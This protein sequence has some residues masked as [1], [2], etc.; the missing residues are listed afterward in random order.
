[1]QTTRKA[2][3]G[4]G[5]CKHASSRYTRSGFSTYRRRR[6]YGCRR[7]SATIRNTWHI[8][9]FAMLIFLLTMMMIV[10]PAIGSETVDRQANSLSYHAEDTIPTS[11]QLLVVADVIQPMMSRVQTIQMQTL[12][13]NAASSMEPVEDSIDD[14]PVVEIDPAILLA[15]SLGNPTIEIDGSVLTRY[16]LPDKYYPGIDFSSFQPYMGYKCITN[17]SSPAYKVTRSEMAYNDEY[18]MRRY[19]T[20]PDQFTI[21]GQDD[22][23]IA[24]GTFYKEKGTAGS[25]YLIVTSTGMYTAIAGDEKSD[26]HTDA[27]HMFSTHQDGSCAGIIEWIVDQENLESTMK[28][29][30]TITAGPIEP[31]KGEILHIYGIN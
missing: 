5:G 1:M 2:S 28:R 17:K 15:E 9:A 10:I 16:D 20:T 22:Y 8:I 11:D 6:G 7:R 26:A 29:A 13:M 27:R 4:Y 31:L 21:D 24:L 3:M 23:V 30:G 19:R 18:G 12:V 25:R 14:P